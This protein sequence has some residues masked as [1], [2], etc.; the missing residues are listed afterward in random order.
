MS[1]HPDW[2]IKAALGMGAALLIFVAAWLGERKR[3]SSWRRTLVVAGIA[4]AAGLTFGWAALDL[5]RENFFLG[6]QLRAI[7]MLCLA[8]VVP[9]AAG[10]AVTRGDQLSGFAGALTASAWRSGN[11]VTPVLTLLFVAT[12]VVSL[13]VALGLVFDPRYKD[14]PVASL[15]A[16][17]VALFMLAFMRTHGPLRP[18]PAEIAAALLLFGSSAFIIVNEGIA[19][20]QAVWLAILLILMA[21]TTLRAK[22]EPG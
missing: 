3:E 15:T 22:A 16:P 1:D 17:V 13:H 5:T 18:G 8:V 6:D 21:L 7:I 19:N 11:W 20:W 9:M 14:F 10:F 4:L 2:A 12:V